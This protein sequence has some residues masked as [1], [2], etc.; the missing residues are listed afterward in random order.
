MAAPATGAA[1]AAGAAPAVSAAAPPLEP[2][3]RAQNGGRLIY[4]MRQSRHVDVNAIQ[5]DEN[6][7]PFLLQQYYQ[8]CAAAVRLCVSVCVIESV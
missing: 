1:R 2:H 4:V 3:L 7:F 5:V 8:R 6:E